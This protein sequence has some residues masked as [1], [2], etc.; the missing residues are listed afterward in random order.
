MYIYI[1][2]YIYIRLLRAKGADPNLLDT[3]NNTVLHMLVVHDKKVR[4]DNKKK[5]L[6]SSHKVLPLLIYIMDPPLNII[7]I[8][9]IYIYI[10]YI[11]YIYYIIYIIYIL[12]HIY[13]IYIIYMYI[14]ILY[15]YI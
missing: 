12:H 7:Y 5:W 2:I 6:K 15:I 3:N 4:V 13:Y 11:L 14:Y 10:S 9:N 8:Y 1:Y